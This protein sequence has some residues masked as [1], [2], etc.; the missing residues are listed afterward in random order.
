MVQLGPHVFIITCEVTVIICS[1][2]YLY[3]LS[4]KFVGITSHRT[5]WPMD[6]QGYGL[7]LPYTG[8]SLTCIHE[9]F[10]FFD[11]SKVSR[12]P[13]SHRLVGY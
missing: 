6:T 11:E 1:A 2:F 9:W 3:I 4:L 5:I 12:V 10:F 13:I 7:T 8:R